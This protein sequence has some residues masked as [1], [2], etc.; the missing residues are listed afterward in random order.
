MTDQHIS[1]YSL[2][3][4]KTIKWWKKVFWG[5]VDISILNSWIIYSANFSDGEI[6]SHRMFRIEL[7]HDLVQPLLTL[8]ANP[9]CPVS[10]LTKGQRPSASEKRLL[11]KHFPYQKG[12]RER[13]VVCYKEKT[14][15]GKRK[16]TKTSVYCSKCDVSLCIGTCFEDYHTKSKY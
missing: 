10:Y 16:D 12:K 11:G 13:C 5:M 3:Q 15:S 1:Y 7:A 4:R 9:E 6:T 14:A 2:T 8:K